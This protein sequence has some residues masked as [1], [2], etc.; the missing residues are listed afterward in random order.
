MSYTVRVDAS[1]FDNTM[2]GL[3]G[4]IKGL[5]HRI[6]TESADITR[7]QL[8]SNTPVRTGRLRDSISSS[9]DS[10][11]AIIRTNTGY[12]GYVELGT[13][14]FVG[15]FYAAKTVTEIIPKIQTLIR[16]IMGDLR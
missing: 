1:R 7:Q 11:K 14:Y 16:K 4:T 13:R 12:G 5:P 6:L 8:R 10:R 3:I 9:V 15:R 2:E